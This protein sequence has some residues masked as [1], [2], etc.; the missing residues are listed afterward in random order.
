MVKYELYLVT[1]DVQE[2]AAMKLN[3]LK[4]KKINKTI[5]LNT[6]VESCRQV[7]PRPYCL[8]HF[9]STFIGVQMLYKRHAKH[10]EPE[11]L[12][13]TSFDTPYLMYID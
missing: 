5:P 12:L 2:V 11:F 9:R 8:S 3:V 10:R 7:D 13:H 4:E 1:K 6:K